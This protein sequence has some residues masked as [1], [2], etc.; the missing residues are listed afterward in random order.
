M[1]TVVAGISSRISARRRRTSLAFQVYV[2]VLER[3][4]DVLLNLGCV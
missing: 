1:A 4:L 2:A 3:A